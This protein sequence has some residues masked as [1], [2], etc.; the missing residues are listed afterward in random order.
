MARH[1]YPKSLPGA[2][3]PSQVG[4]AGGVWRM[5]GRMEGQGLCSAALTV[6]FPLFVLQVPDL[7]FNYGGTHFKDTMSNKH[8]ASHTTREKTRLHSHPPCKALCFKT[9]HWFQ[10]MIIRAACFFSSLALNSGSY[11]LS[12]L[13]KSESWKP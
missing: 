5:Q 7:S 9:L 6:G 2:A 8:T 10:P 1:R 12:S 11:I 4:G 13:T 3:Q